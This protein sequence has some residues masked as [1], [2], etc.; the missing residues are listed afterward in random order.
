[1]SYRYGGYGAY[2]AEMIRLG[3]LPELD[4][5]FKNRK[6]EGARSEDDSGTAGTGGDVRASTTTESDTR[7]KS[8]K[9]RPT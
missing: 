4:P 9:I 7:V 5:K 6:L 3:Q 2:L 8:T 1:M